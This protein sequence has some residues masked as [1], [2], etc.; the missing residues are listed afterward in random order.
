MD[1]QI[2]TLKASAGY[3]ANYESVAEVVVKQTAV[4]GSDG[5]ALQSYSIEASDLDIDRQFEEGGRTLSHGL[6]TTYWTAHGNRDPFEV[7]VEVIILTRQ[8]NAMNAIATRAEAEFNRLFDKHKKAISKLSEHRRATYERLRLA[9]PKPT[10]VT[11]HL[12]DSI[13]FR[14]SPTD[15][16]WD[17]HLYI[18]DNGK[19]RAELSPWEDGVIEIELK[20]DD[21]VAWLRN[22]DRQPWSLEIPYESGGK[23]MPMFPDLVVVRKVGDDFVFDVLEPHDPSLD[24]NFEKAVGFAKFAEEHG[25]LFGRIEMLRAAKGPASKG[26]FVGLDFNQ[27]SV[28]KKV[29]LITSN[30]QLNALFDSDGK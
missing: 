28:R 10:A 30:P 6:H 7:K 26:A 14:R 25:A 12:P 4:Q 21:V 13:N 8:A 18:E 1:A 11:W 17:R 9:T 2:A 20:R 22:V 29:L 24:D 15:P 27:T 3:E 23:V 16:L 5:V 19:F